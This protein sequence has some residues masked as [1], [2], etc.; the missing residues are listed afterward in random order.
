MIARILLM[1]VHCNGP[2]LYSGNKSCLKHAELP[3]NGVTM[4][5][6][7]RLMD[8]SA[9]GQDVLVNFDIFKEAGKPVPLLLCNVYCN[10]YR[11]KLY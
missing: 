11:R 4:Q 7:D 2:F 9:Q 10:S 6:G 3:D 8:I 5:A 1:H